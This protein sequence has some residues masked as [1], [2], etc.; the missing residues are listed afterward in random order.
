ME[1]IMRSCSGI[2]RVRVWDTKIYRGFAG[3]QRTALE[4]SGISARFEAAELYF[5]DA[6][7]QALCIAVLIFPKDRRLLKR[8]HLLTNY[9]R[10]LPVLSA[11]GLV[12]RLWE[13]GGKTKRSA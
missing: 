9:L 4:C 13:K 3:D 1:W 11:Y 12:E 10:T 7:A 5:S 6:C 2:P 8:V